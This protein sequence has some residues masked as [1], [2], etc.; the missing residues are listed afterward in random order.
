MH[1]DKIAQSIKCKSTYN[2]AKRDKHIRK[3]NSTA[4]CRC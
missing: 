1:Q 3:A 4:F 2:L